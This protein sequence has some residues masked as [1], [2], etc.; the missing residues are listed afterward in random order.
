MY[1]SKKGGGCKV[2]NNFL[3]QTINSWIEFAKEHNQ[4]E[5][6]KK[7]FLISDFLT[8]SMSYEFLRKHSVELFE[9]LKMIKNDSI[10]NEIEGMIENE[11]MGASEE[12]SLANR[13]GLEIW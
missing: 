4:P 5:N 7:L 3:N 2:I 10:R 8:H 13:D 9:A 6:M 12:S 1:S 11:L